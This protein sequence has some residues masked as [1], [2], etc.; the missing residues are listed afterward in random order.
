VLERKS[1]KMKRSLEQSSH[2]KENQEL[3]AIK[4]IIK[5]DMSKL[6]QDKESMLMILSSVPRIVVEPACGRDVATLIDLLRKEIDEQEAL[7]VKE[8]TGLWFNRGIMIDAYK[9]GNLYVQKFKETDINWCKSKF[10]TKLHDSCMVIKYS[11]STLPAFCVIDE[12]DHID[13]IW[14]EKSVRNLG[15]AKSF[16]DHFDVKEVS[17]VIRESEGFWNKCGVHIKSYATM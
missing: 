2:E 16:V 5:L 1:I 14:T 9:E 15:I 3:T 4:K 13:L 6:S 17:M 10:W 8:P 11:R 12:D 7:G